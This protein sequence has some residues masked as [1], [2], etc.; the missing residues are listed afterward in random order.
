MAKFTL[1]TALRYCALLAFLGLS[2]F[3]WLAWPDAKPLKAQ[4]SSSPNTAYVATTTDSRAMGYTDARKAVRDRNNHLY[5]AYRTTYRLN[6]VS[7]GQRIFVAKS[8]DNGLSWRVLN[9]RPI[10]DVGNYTQRVPAI[11]I[12]NSDRLH[13]VWY[14]LDAENH[15]SNNRQIKYASSSDGGATWSPWRNIGLVPGYNNSTLWQEHPVIYAAPNN[16][17]YVVWEGMD[18]AYPTAAQVKFL[19]STDGGQNWGAWRNIA[20]STSTKLSRPTLVTS[21]DG[22]QLY[23]IA[24]NSTSSTFANIVWSRSNDDGESWS[25]WQVVASSSKDQRHV[26]ATVDRQGRI[27]VAWRQQPE[28]SPSTAP[29]QLHYAFFANGAWSAMQIPAPQSDLYQFFPSITSDLSTDKLWLAWTATSLASGY[30]NEDAG[31]GQGYFTTYTSAGWSSPTQLAAN[32]DAIYASL[33]RPAGNE[34]D[35]VWL[36]NSTVKPICHAILNQPGQPNAQ[37]STTCARWEQ[38]TPTN[39]PTFTPTNTPTD[40]PVPTNV[41]TNTPTST[42]TPTNM[43]VP[44]TPSA[45]LQAFVEQGG[46]VV[47]EAENFQAKVDRSNY[48]WV[49][50]TTLAGYVGNGAMFASPNNGATIK[51]NISTTSPQLLYRA[52]FTATGTYYLWLRT[53]APTSNDDALYI[54]ID[55]QKPAAQSTGS[56]STWRW[57]KRSVTIKTA[58]LHT[59]SFWMQKDG[60]YVDRFL[61]TINKSYVPSG[62]GPAESA[63]TTVTSGVQFAALA[64]PDAI[65]LAADAAETTETEN[66]LSTSVLTSVELISLADG[67]QAALGEPLLLAAQ[68]QPSLADDFDRTL[69]IR[70]YV[71]GELIRGCEDDA[72]Q[73]CEWMPPAAG[74]YAFTVKAALVDDGSLPEG[75]GEVVSPTVMVSVVDVPQTADDPALEGERTR[76]F[77]PLIQG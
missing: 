6:G 76:T 8:T 16:T 30:P 73:Q 52:L 3:Y 1:L 53:Q 74:L 28:G 47:I 72:A 4:T 56:G 10:E 70:I 22:S 54:S 34:I 27:H 45:T 50:S 11:A 62:A 49:L 26:S 66:G 57:S 71:N 77:L 48:A 14:G 51:S 36:E 17:L 31:S 2:L 23:V 18:A 15:Q 35:I 20:A 19:K 21:L 32:V 64:A 29:T 12:D 59:V 60:L 61:L 58:G 42:L 63:L 75:A 33:S 38:P 39:T 13:V 41:P 25:T 40:T 67:M 69:S 37:S 5:V 24:Y 44:S 9:E 65:I 43:P 55:T 7:Q 68:T 46:Q